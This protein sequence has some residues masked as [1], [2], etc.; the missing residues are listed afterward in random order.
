MKLTVLGSG[1]MMPTQARYPAAYLV[2]HGDTKLLLDC[3]HMAMAR[4]IKH[5]GPELV[6]ALNAVLV[7]HFHTDHFWGLPALIHSRW[8]DDVLAGRDNEELTVIGPDTLGERLH[9]AREISW[10]EPGESYSM[11]IK[12]GSLTETVGDVSITSFPINHVPWFKSV[13]FCLEADGKSL[14]F[15]GDLNA[16]QDDEFFAGLAKTDVLLIEAGAVKADHGTHL[17]PQQA[18]AWAKQYRVKKVVLTHL[19]PSGISAIEE[20][21]ASEPELAIVAHDGL[22]LDLSPGD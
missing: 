11:T 13:G 2:E 1:T 22:T 20:I 8:V 10:P 14:V 5:G 12:E 7:T 16:Q 4:L 17:T 9:K 21:A 3:S 18:L 19:R 15:T 6:Q